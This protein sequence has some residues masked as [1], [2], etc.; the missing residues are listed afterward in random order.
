[1]TNLILGPIK[2][3]VPLEVLSDGSSKYGVG[4]LPLV[5]H[6]GGRHS[7]RTCPTV[8]MNRA[9][10]TP[11]PPLL[12][13]TYSLHYCCLLFK[14]HDSQGKLAVSSLSSKLY[15]HVKSVLRRCADSA[16]RTRSSPKTLQR[17]PCFS[18]SPSKQV[19]YTTIVYISWASRTAPQQL[20][21]KIHY[22]TR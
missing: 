6:K 9:L 21:R 11:S 14:V 2:L 17:Q 18:G 10:L 13:N 19:K 3:D 4:G 22:R 1:M 15:H 7:P 16:E 5:G 20:S 8:L 12:N